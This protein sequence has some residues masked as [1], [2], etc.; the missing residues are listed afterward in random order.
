[1]SASGV[2][3]SCRSVAAPCLP[4][5]SLPASA[6]GYEAAGRGCAGASVPGDGAVNVL[7]DEQVQVSCRDQPASSTEFTQ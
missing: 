5:D 3:L 6:P 2:S 4:S 7:P 1:M